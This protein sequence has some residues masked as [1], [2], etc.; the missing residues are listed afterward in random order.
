MPGPI[1]PLQPTFAR[2][3]LSPRL[4][5]R[6]DIDHWKMGLAECVNWFVMKQG[7]LRRRPGFEW[8]AETKNS[9]KVR[10]EEFIFSTVQAYV[11]EFGDHYIRFYAN[12]GIVN[13]GTT[14]AISMLNGVVTWPSLPVGNTAPLV[15]STQGTLPSPL[16]QGRTYYIRD[17]VGNQFHIS[18]SPGSAA[19]SFTGANSGVTGAISPV[20]VAT[21]YD[22]NDIWQLQLSQSADILYIASPLWAPRT[23]SRTSANVF[24]LAYYEYIDGPYLPENQTPTTL[25][26]SG[27]SGNVQLTASSTVGI[28]N[29]AG[30]LESD[31]GR[32]V[33]LQYSSKWYA[34][35]I[36]SVGKLV[37][38]NITIS[39][40]NPAVVSWPAHGRH[41]SEAI[42]F[43][44]TGTLPAPIIPNQTYYLK[45]VGPNSF[46]LA[47]V[48]HVRQ[49]KNEGSVNIAASEYVPWSVD[50]SI[51]I[52]VGN[53]VYWTSNGLALNDNVKFTTLPPGLGGF[54]VN[55]IYYVVPD[56][57]NGSI[58][59]DYVCLSA[60]PSGQ[61]ISVSGGDGK[62][63]QDPSTL[64]Q[65]FA[66]AN[67]VFIFGASVN[68]AG[69]TQSGTH[70]A[71]IVSNNYC[72]AEVEGLVD[73][74][75]DLV[76]NLP[77]TGATG[78]WKMGAWSATT[79]WPSVVCFYQQR[80]VWGRTDTQPQTVWFSKA[81]V[82]TN[83]ATTEPAQVDDAIT[84]TILAGEVNAIQWIA[85][86]A[87]LLTGTTGAM[88]TIGPADTSKPFGATNVTQ[89]RQSTFGSRNLQPVQVGEVAIYASYYGLSLREFLFSFQQ[90]S[91]V[92]PELTILSEH[93]LR[94]GIQQFTFAQ[95]KESMVWMAMGNGELVG[96][97]YDRDQQI[98][99][100][101]RHRVGGEC[102]NSGIVDPLHPSDT[103]T[104]YGVVESVASIPGANR[105]E[106]WA[107]IRRTFQFGGATVTKRYVERLT[108][109]FEAQLKETAIFMDASFNFVSTTPVGTVS[110]VYWLAG[111]EIAILA[112]GAVVPRV[113][114]SNTGSFTLANNKKAK[115]ITFGLPY[116]SRATTLPLAMGG[117]DGTG[118]GRLRNIVSAKLDYME[119]GYLEVGS[120]RARELEVAV[121]L[122][123]RN[124]PMDT[125]PPLK[126]G[127]YEHRFD[128]TW[129]DAGQIIIQSDKPLPATVRSISAVFIMEP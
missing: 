40:A 45:N 111:Q 58:G 108:P 6:A 115:R 76:P 42:R 11:L 57:S 101:T 35:Q 123:G 71:S 4:F 26:P 3:E 87:D 51:N 102:K 8:I 56:P 122:R 53:K 75:G 29:G 23:L 121:G 72:F 91:Y 7:G 126:D 94:S 128:R 21:P 70:S 39:S 32:W 89:R 37:N 5:S 98:V 59:P 95:D 114:V 19:I 73:E 81:G 10:L 110:G 92:S 99:A 77:G 16:Q 80:L 120:P 84:L 44:T 33:T 2:G 66:V 60:T 107:T 109:P 43:T 105:H 24:T 17:R 86:A 129:K 14:N 90:N 47:T 48:P 31:V 13:N 46:E 97:T 55:T 124:D 25:Q 28:N 27:V 113:T 106:L 18:D 9:Q 88:R 61:P 103:T 67:E 78:G 30:F 119:T 100:M 36:S 117:G 62:P 93:M 116:T 125:S 74:K 104:H 15:F 54:V 65:G 69:S 49:V 68:T 83:F 52:E 82:I 22:A 20:E 96:L 12:G 85:E 34:L 63:N 79:G 38:T 1:Y 118:L 112:D 41:N 64:P 127:I 50:P